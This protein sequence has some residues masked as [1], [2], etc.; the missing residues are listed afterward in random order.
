VDLD[1]TFSFYHLPLSLFTLLSF[2]YFITLPL[3]PSPFPFLK[4]GE[5]VVNLRG[6]AKFK[7]GVV[8][9]IKLILCSLCQNI[10]IP[11]TKYRYK[12]EIF[13]LFFFLIFVKGVQYST[14]L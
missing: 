8:L 7:R 12:K 10:N 4:E 13:F 9:T 5:R 3:H 14:E 6:G 2:F 11:Q 1:I